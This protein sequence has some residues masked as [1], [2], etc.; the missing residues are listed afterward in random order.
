MT[1]TEADQ[2]NLT[3]IETPEQLGFL[4]AD[5][6]R[7]TSVHLLSIIEAPADLEISMALADEE[8]EKLLTPE[9]LKAFKAGIEYAL[10]QFATLPFTP[11]MEESNEELVQDTGDGSQLQ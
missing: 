7:N 1:K 5:W 4:V 6:H 3:R 11:V 9:Q 2:Q 8:E 10:N